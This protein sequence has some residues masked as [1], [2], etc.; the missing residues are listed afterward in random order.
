MTLRLDDH[1]LEGHQ[2]P[3]VRIWHEALNGE[4]PAAIARWLRLTRAVVDATLAAEPPEPIRDDLRRLSGLRGFWV[5]QRDGHG[6]A[7][8]RNADGAPHPFVVILV[9]HRIANRA[10]DAGMRAARREIRDA[11]H[12]GF[13]FG[14]VS[15]R[16]PLWALLATARRRDMPVWEIDAAGAARPHDGRLFRLLDPPSPDLAEAPSPS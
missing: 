5:S 6:P 7:Q 16:A 4:T 1:E 14:T 2:D 3:A 13:D 8:L 10:L 11:G 15:E 9:P 12:P